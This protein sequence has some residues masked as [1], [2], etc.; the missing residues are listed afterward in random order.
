MIAQGV[1]PKR[2]IPGLSKTQIPVIAT[3]VVLMLMVAFGAFKYKHFFELSNFEG[4]VK[5]NAYLGIVAVGMTFVIIAGGI[6]LSVGAVVGT[7]GVVLAT[8]MAKGMSLQTAVPLVLLIGVV[9]GAAMGFLI[10]K[11]EIAPF[12]VTLAGMF[13]ARGV[14]L[15]IN[16]DSIEI[17]NKL[18]DR[19]NDFYYGETVALIAVLIVGAVLLH[20]TP[21]G[22]SVF[23]IGCNE[24]SSKLMGLPVY[25][26]KVSIYAISGFCSAL[27]GVIY[28]LSM[29]SAAAKVC[30]GLEL[31]AIAAVVIG[32]TLLT[33]GI[34]TIVGT[35]MGFLTL[36]IIG[37]ITNFANIDSWWSKI[38]V[39][40][41]L[42]AFILL[43]KV[44][45]VRQTNTG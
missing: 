18:V 35:L 22:R 12:L 24:T 31:D 40:G 13:L 29:S 14:G 9:F 2:G 4:I 3:T 5:G 10:A 45:S 1:Q 43:Q 15:V 39:G 8:L 36:G 37:S 27:A 28:A 23:A 25:R 32:G 20:L 26:T 30:D 16:Q 6:D 21:F 33:G 41:L 17:S 38:M 42:C 44:V 19:F 7:I 11:F 34:G